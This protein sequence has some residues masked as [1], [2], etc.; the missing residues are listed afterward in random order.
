MK[1]IYYNK[2][3]VTGVILAGGLARRMD[4]Q[5][6]G[7]LVLAHKPMIEYV[8]E[9]FRHQVGPLLINANRHP[10]AYARYHY[11]VIA[12]QIEGY[13]GPLAGFASAMQ[14]C[15]T[16]YIVSVPCDSP[17]IP[18]DLVG[19]LFHSLHEEDTDISVAH[20]GERIQPVF[21]LLKCELL[22]SI[23]NYLDSGERKIDRWISRHACSVV[24]F[25]DQPDTFLNINTPD[26]LAT[27]EQE[28]YRRKK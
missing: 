28:L 26:D 23:R 9:S 21:A 7:L 16:G 18:D 14:H 17:F 12:D 5:D 2:Q 3:D 20:N 8:I 25:S 13:C 10:E 22:D 15:K 11:P 4:G 19:R 1:N 24:D 6:K 27:L